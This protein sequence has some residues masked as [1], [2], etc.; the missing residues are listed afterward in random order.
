MSNM[1]KE[2]KKVRSKNK[3]LSKHNQLDGKI[4]I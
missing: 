1:F 4:A 3:E 2:T